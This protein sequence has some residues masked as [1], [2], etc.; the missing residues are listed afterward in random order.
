[1]FQLTDIRGFSKPFAKAV[2]DPGFPVG[3]VD[4]VGEGR[5][6]PRQVCFENFVCQN[7]RI[8]TLRGGV[9]WAHPP[10]DPPMQ[11]FGKESLPITVCDGIINLSINKSTCDFCQIFLL[12]KGFHAILYGLPNKI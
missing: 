10:L 9:R 11:R 2:E 3:G 6:L 1:M 7:E 8:G 12:D 5:G 4:L